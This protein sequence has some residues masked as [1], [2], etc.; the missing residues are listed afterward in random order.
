MKKIV[1]VKIRGLF[2]KIMKNVKMWKF[3]GLFAKIMKHVK[4]WK[5]MGLF[6]KI[7]KMWK[8]EGLF[9]KLMKNVK[10]WRLEVLLSKLLKTKCEN[11]K[12]RWSSWINY[13]TL[14]KQKNLGSNMRKENLRG[15]KMWK[16]EKIGNFA[17]KRASS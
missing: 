17:K 4:M 15:V 5:L 2:A 14:W 6:A 9:A 16:R 1:N 8:I 13:E 7:M 3:E 11:W 12:F 10:M